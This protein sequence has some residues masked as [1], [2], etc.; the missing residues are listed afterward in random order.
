MRRL[1]LLAA[2]VAIAACDSA[3]YVIVGGGT[4]GLLL[5]NR[6]SSNPDT[7][8]AVIDPGPD[9]RGNPIVRNPFVWE[10]LIGG[11]VDWLYHT[12][13]QAN[14][15]GRTINMDAGKGIGGT[16]LINGASTQAGERKGC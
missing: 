10:Q 15:S 12:V 4:A 8:V 14:L 5:A 13:P 16:S 11:S 3:D 7:S 2:T 1:F 9:E 6:L